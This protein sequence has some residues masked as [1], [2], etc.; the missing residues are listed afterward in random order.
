MIGRVDNEIPIEILPQGMVR[1]DQWSDNRR[2][3]QKKE[4][5]TTEG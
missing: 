1:R 2:Y 5:S 4:N 3:D